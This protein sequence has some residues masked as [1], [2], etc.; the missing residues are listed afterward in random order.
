MSIDE[1]E[2]MPPYEIDF[3]VLMLKEWMEKQAQEARKLGYSV[4]G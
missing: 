2:E 4:G 3:Y 1:A